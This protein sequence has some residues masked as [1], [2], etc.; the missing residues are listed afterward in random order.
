VKRTDGTTSNT[1]SVGIASRAPRLLLLSGGY[2]AIVNADAC[3]G[4]TPC[5][6]G[7]S[8]PFPASFSQPGYPAYPAKAGDTLVLY[9]IGLGATSPS[10]SSG[11]P[12][13]SSAPL[14]QLTTMPVIRFGD[15]P[16]SPTATPSFAGL[17]PGFAGLYQI[18]V[19]I[20]PDAPKGV[21][22]ISA[23]FPDSTSNIV[24]IAIQ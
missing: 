20:P 4:I 17:S 1:V 15:N 9:A 23:A 11:Q 2:G 6:L 12:A 16:L 10:V 7:G 14:A 21:I 19:Q 8:L 18:N 22:G 13:P 5:L 3:G 24:L